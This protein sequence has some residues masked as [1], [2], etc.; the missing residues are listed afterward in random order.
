MKKKKSKSL[1]SAI[2]IAVV[3]SVGSYYGLDLSSFF[4]TE[5]TAEQGET[6]EVIKVIDGDTIKINYKGK[7]ENIRF[8]LI[9]TPEM[10]HKQFDGPQPFAVEAK[11]KVE[12]LLVGGKVD[13][14]IGVQERDKYGRLLGYLYVNGKSIQDEL[15]REGLAR[16]AY[17][18][19]DKRHLE[20]Y[21]HIEKEAKKS[22]K[23]I[24]SIEN[25]VT[26][27]GFIKVN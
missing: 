25:Y 24:W 5:Q 21:L 18:Y 6:F 26:E 17:V 8:L 1:L 14:E 3:I 20:R 15:L 12:D 19:N 9:D 23:G 11:E 7:H 16:V 22:G 4:E 2:L 27:N 13:V 10:S